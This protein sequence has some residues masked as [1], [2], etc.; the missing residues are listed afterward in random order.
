MKTTRRR[1]IKLGAA[2]G[3][4]LYLSTKIGGVRYLVRAQ[5]PGGSLDPLGIPRFS[6]P[7]LIP[8]VMPRAGTIRLTGGQN[9]D[10]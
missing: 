5:I 3:G 7:L 2:A 4:G 1:F 6:T 8:P 9:A 10:Y